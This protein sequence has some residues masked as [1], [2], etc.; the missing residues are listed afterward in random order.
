[1]QVKEPARALRYKDQDGREL[2]FRQVR[3]SAHALHANLRTCRC[4][5]FAALMILRL[6]TAIDSTDE[7]KLCRSG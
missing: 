4:Q 1:M 7:G 5:P 3:H 2:D 6:T